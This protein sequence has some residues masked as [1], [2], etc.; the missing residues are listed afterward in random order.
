[1]TDFWYVAQLL[2][3]VSDFMF[4]RSGGFA[5]GFT[6]KLPHLLALFFAFAIGGSVVHADHHEESQFRHA[7]FFKF[8]DSATDNNIQQ[9]VDEFMLLKGFSESVE[10]L[11]DEFTHCFFV[12]FKDKA[13]LE[14]YVPHPDHQAFVAILKPHL[15]KVFVFDYAPKN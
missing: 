5:K 13:G 9:I 1:M 11:N 12:T 14:A 8:K 3:F 2:M 4:D 7:V 6:M 15:E 10:G